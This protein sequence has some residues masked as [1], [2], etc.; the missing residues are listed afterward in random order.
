MTPA[1]RDAESQIAVDFDDTI[2]TIID[3]KLVAKK[4]VVEALAK[5]KSAGYKITIHSARCWQ[6]W[7]DTW[8][9]VAEMHEFLE[10]NKIP[11]DGIYMGIG[12]PAAVAYIDDKAIRFKDN[13]EDIAEWLAFKARSSEVL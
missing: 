7:P 10:K 4:G 3:G 11:Y 13:W 2:A 1:D 9:R 5:I 6:A 12:K 8:E